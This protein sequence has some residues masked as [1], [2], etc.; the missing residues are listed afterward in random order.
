MEKLSLLQFPFFKQ[1]GG[2]GLKTSA[3]RYLRAIAHVS[4]EEVPVNQCDLHRVLLGMRTWVVVQAPFAAL[5]VADAVLAPAPQSPRQ[6]IPVGRCHCSH[7][8][9]T[10]H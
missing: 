7:Y 10:I 5:C 9:P 8:H 2:W 1:P 4:A 3:P 6:A